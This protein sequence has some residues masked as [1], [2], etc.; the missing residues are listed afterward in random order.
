MAN[1]NT[2]K[3]AT[4]N[5]KGNKHSE[6]PN[7]SVRINRLID[8]N[9]NTKAYASVNIGGA[10]AVHGLKVIDSRKGLFVNM[11][12]R[13]YKDENGVTKYA[14]QFHA[15]TADARNA[16]NDAVLDA[17]EQA[18]AQA[19]C[20]SEDEDFEEIEDESEGLSPTM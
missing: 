10:F 1:K 14:D 18:V 6:T 4:K 13:P 11:P 3:N 9:S 7:I 16:L 12:S 17:Y 20:E 19:Q 8:D 2:A 15:I 5:A